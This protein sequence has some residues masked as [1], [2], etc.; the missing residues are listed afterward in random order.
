MDIKIAL[1]TKTWTWLNWFAILF[2]SLGLYVAFAFFG[3]KLH[4]FKSFNTVASI[5]DGYLVWF[6][7]AFFSCL[8]FYIDYFSLIFEKEVMTPMRIYF[9][10]IMRKNKENDP[11]MFESVITATGHKKPTK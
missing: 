7:I 3:D 1:F 4:M 2:L 6:I 9:T 5:T 10:S 8:A 11:N